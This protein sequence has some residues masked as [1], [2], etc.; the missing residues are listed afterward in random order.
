MTRT[1]CSACGSGS[2]TTARSRGAT[3][4]AVRRAVP[5]TR[6]GSAHGA[7]TRHSW[8]VPWRAS[9]SSPRSGGPGAAGMGRRVAA[10]SGG[11]VSSPHPGGRRASSGRVSTAS[12]SS[13][14]PTSAALAG[15]A[16][17]QGWWGHGWRAFVGAAGGRTPPGWCRRPP[18]PPTCPPLTCASTAHGRPGAHGRLRR[19]AA[20]PGPH[21]AGDTAGPSAAGGTT[22]PPS[23]VRP[24]LGAPEARSTRWGPR[25][26]RSQRRSRRAPQ[27]C[28]GAAP[29][30]AW[31]QQL[32]QWSCA[33]TPVGVLARQAPPC[34]WPAAFS[35]RGAL[36]SGHPLAENLSR[37][38]C[39]GTSQ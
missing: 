19:A 6:R 20:P 31:P 21:P 12:P 2:S 27:R 18:G 23:P 30:A 7:K 17:P 8:A 22:P 33:S 29:G 15:G 37:E 36:P 25:P 10:P 16:I 38:L 4:T 34:L 9:A 13:L 32:A 11:L 26:Q 24:R 35:S 5:G 14:A 1:S 3:S 39:R 28:G